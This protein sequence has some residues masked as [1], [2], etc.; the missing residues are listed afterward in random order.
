MNSVGGFHIEFIYHIFYCRDR[1]NLV[2]QGIR[3]H[4]YNLV[5]NA[6]EHTFLVERA[7]VG[8]LRLAIRLLRREEIAPQVLTSLRILL[9]MKPSVVHNIARHIAYGL[10]D[11]LRTNAANIHT[12]QD[13]FTLFTLLEVIGAGANPPPILQVCSG[14]KMPEDILEAGKYCVI[15]M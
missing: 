13:W 10:H 3:D 5:V 7:V 14:V 11:L 9:M 1:V 2:W 4:I 12:G 15:Y 6:S 8:L